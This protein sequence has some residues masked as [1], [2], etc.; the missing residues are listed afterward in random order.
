MKRL[1]CEI[2][3]LF[4]ELLA[5]GREYCKKPWVFYPPFPFTFNLQLNY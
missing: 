1:K 2:T 3:P 4:R 5:I